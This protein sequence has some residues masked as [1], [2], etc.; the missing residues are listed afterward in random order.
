MKSRILKAE[1]LKGLPIAQGIADR[2]S[3]MPM[4]TNA[5]TSA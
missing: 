1:F 3:T 5:F 2:K 4:L